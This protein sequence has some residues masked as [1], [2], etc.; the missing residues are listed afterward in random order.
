MCSTQAC[1]H[2]FS[3]SYLGFHTRRWW[4]WRATLG[5]MMCLP[6]CCHFPVRRRGCHAMP[7]LSIL[8]GKGLYCFARALSSCTLDRPIHPREFGRLGR[9]CQPP[10]RLR[11][12]P[13][14]FASLMA[15]QK[16][17][18]AWIGVIE[19]SQGDRP[20]RRRQVGYGTRWEWSKL[21]RS[22]RPGTA[23][24]RRPS[25]KYRDCADEVTS[26]LT[27]PTAGPYLSTFFFGSNHHR[28]QSFILP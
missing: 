28:P 15:R 21:I 12:L 4:A 17:S 1:R 10:K 27:Q 18:L 16:R 13:T 25:D 22:S 11:C 19:S 9:H 7:F 2:L 26:K 24:V 8:L 6:E 5:L 3:V 14:S 20:T 23:R